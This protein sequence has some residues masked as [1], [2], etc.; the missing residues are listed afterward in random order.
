MHALVDAY[1]TW[2]LAV[3]SNGLAGD[4]VPPA[5][6]VSVGSTQITEMDL[7]RESHTSR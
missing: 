3:G 5:D 1:M 7:F 2:M 6:A 4:Y